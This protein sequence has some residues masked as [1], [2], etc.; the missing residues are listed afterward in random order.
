MT[1]EHA[2]RMLSDLIDGTPGLNNSE[3][4]RRA[5]VSL[6]TIKNYRKGGPATP[7]KLRLV[8]GIFQP[9][10]AARLC[11]AFGYPGL[12]ANKERVDAAE[13]L[14]EAIDEARAALA[15]LEAAYD[16]II[17]TRA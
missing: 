1:N 5:G 10:D 6:N 4:A 7:S 13:I 12:I 16:R 11:E 17:Q 15:Q 2:G 3:A 14:R 9:D 8:A